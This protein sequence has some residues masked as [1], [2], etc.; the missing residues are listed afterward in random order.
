MHISISGVKI[1]VS[2]ETKELMSYVMTWEASMI[3]GHGHNSYDHFITLQ[4]GGMLM[5]I[6]LNSSVEVEARERSRTL[7]PLKWG[8]IYVL[9][10]IFWFAR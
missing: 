8:L 3:F 2:L 9:Q 5:S 10:I 4:E 7:L 6:G 1:K